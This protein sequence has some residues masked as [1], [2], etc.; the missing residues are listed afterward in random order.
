[1]AGITAPPRS[2]MSWHIAMLYFSVMWPATN[3][4]CPASE[5]PTDMDWKS[6]FKNIDP[7]NSENPFAVHS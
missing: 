5:K 7:G 1:M 4:G 2:R 3:Q 6:L